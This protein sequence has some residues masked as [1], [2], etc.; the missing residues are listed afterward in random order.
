[1]DHI[2]PSPEIALP[3]LPQLCP[4]IE[5]A[6][7]R[8][9]PGFRLWLRRLHPPYRRPPAER[10]SPGLRGHLPRLDAGPPPQPAPL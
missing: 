9:G 2:E 10:R 3:L 6:R 5:P 4:P 1:M 7:Q 8:K